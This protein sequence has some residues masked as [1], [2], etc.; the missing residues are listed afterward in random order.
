MDEPVATFRTAFFPVWRLVTAL[1]SAGV[2]ALLLVLRFGLGV[3]VHVPHVLVTALSAVVGAAVVAVPLGLVKV[4]LRWDG[5]RCY[6]AYGFYHF[7][8]WGAVEA[9]RPANF[10]GLKYLRVRAAGLPRE[11]WVPLFLADNKGFRRA[12]TELAGPDN[13]L[14]LSLQQHA[15]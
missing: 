12:V 4:Y 10:L 1:S 9:V 5:L 2:G 14:A 6:D 8:P 3:P 11:L 13:P 15:A 7:A